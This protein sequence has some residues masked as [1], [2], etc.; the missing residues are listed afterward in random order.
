MTAAL[1]VSTDLAV[2]YTTREYVTRKRNPDDQWDRDNTRSEHAMQY[3]TIAAQSSWNTVTYPGLVKPNDKVYL[4]FA[5]YSTGD[6]FGRDDGA[7]IALQPRTSACTRNS[8]SR[9]GALPRPT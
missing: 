7:R 6:S 5:V 9:F 8:P 4:L 3:I 2:Y 1:P